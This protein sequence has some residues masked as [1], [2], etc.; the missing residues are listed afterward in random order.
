M[1]AVDTIEAEVR[2][3]VSRR[4]LDPVQAPDSARALVE[5]VVA[6]YA[7]RVLTSALPPVGDRDEVTRSVL[8]AVAGF[9]PLQRHLDDPTVEE[10]WINKRLTDV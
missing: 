5:E 8:D 9:G 6:D 1:T 4:G 3:L 2:E 7:R 10:V